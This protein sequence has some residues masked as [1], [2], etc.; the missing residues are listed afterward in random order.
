MEDLGN[1]TFKH[2][3]WEN[4][5]STDHHENLAV[6]RSEGETRVVEDVFLTPIP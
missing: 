3:F 2:I 4:N 1:V 6:T 5:S